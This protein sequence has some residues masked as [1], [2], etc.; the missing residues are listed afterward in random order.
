MGETTVPSQF[1]GE[2]GELSA[3]RLNAGVFAIVAALWIGALIAPDLATCTY[4]Q[5]EWG[6]GYI[7]LLT[8]WAGPL[9]MFWRQSLGMFAWYGNV[10][11]PICMARML[12]GRAPAV[13]HAIPGLVLALT[14]LAPLSFY[15]EARGV[16]PL[17]GRG[18]GFWLWLAAFAVAAAAATWE[19]SRWRPASAQ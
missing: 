6:R 11:L 8:G 14:A 2:T 13:Q 7:T 9:M 3:N 18:P 17:C 4:G 16:D 12:S 15:S 10:L 19:R 5:P 1:A